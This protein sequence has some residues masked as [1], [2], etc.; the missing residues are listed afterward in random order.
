MLSALRSI[1]RMH[2]SCHEI[3]VFCIKMKTEFFTFHIHIILIYFLTI[4]KFKVLKVVESALQLALYI[5]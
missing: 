4:L 1:L 5:W 2:N 3:K